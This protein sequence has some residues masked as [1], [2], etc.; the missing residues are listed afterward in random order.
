MVVSKNT[1]YHLDFKSQL[2]VS[3]KNVQRQ[4]GFKCF[5]SGQQN[6]IRRNN[7]QSQNQATQQTSNLPI[8]PVTGKIN[9]EAIARQREKEKQNKERSVS[10]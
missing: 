2:F 3:P 8:D 1:I 9:P 6:S 5:N 4:T 7:N 10:S